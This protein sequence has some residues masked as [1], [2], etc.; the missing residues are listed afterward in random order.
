MEVLDKIL[1]EIKDILRTMPPRNT[2][3]TEDALRFIKAAIL[4]RKAG[5]T[6]KVG[7][8]Q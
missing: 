8:G 7:R 4:K 6:Y 1:E 3:D 5:G 2:E